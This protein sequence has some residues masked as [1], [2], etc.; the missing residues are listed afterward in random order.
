MIE[1]FKTLERW[2]R[3]ALVQSQPAEYRWVVRRAA[4]LL[5]GEGSPGRAAG[6][7]Q[8]AGQPVG[9]PHRD[10]AGGQAL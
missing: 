10:R 7:H 3:V 6:G 8:G 1:P 5:T 2:R 9:V 4:A